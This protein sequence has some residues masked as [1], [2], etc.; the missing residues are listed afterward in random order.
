MAFSYCF[1]GDGL[2]YGLHETWI[3]IAN[4]RS[5]N[6]C[7][8]LALRGRP[9]KTATLTFRPVAKGCRLQWRIKTNQIFVMKTGGIMIGIIGATLFIWHLVKV[10]SNP[11]YEGYASHQVMAVN[12]VVL[13]I[14]GTVL[15]FMGK[16]RTKHKRR[17]AA[18]RD[19]K[20]D[21]HV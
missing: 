8:D 21:G 7:R 6:V 9:A 2:G 17:S 20:G 10:V 19:Q 14:F 15:Y 18:V 3:L 4:R 11:D 13:I 12:A 16:R 1:N 5:N